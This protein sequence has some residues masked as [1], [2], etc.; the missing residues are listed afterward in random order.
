MSRPSPF[1]VASQNVLKSITAVYDFIWPTAAALWNLRWQVQGY[2]AARG[3]DV[4]VEELQA[5]FVEGSGIHGAN[6]R[7]AC[8]QQTWEQQRADFAII[9][10]VNLI[11]AYEVWT[12][13]LIHEVGVTRAKA[14]KKKKGEGPKEFSLGRYPLQGVDDIEAELKFLT[15]TPSS[16]MTREVCP[17]LSIGLVH[18]EKLGQM[19]VIYR[20]FKETRNCFMHRGRADEAAVKAYESVG[21]VRDMPFTLPNCTPL[22]RD[23]VV[24]ADLHGVVGFSDV[25]RRLVLTIDSALAASESAEGI[26]VNRWRAECG[27]VQA[28]ADGAKRLSKVRGGL[29]SFGLPR[30]PEV[31]GIAGALTAARLLL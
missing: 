15:G 13:E 21:R 24:V 30:L 1:F 12:D 9:A 29:V 18:R 7:R 11:A 5:R 3:S 8:L 10:L 31:A 4:T 28:P 2:T 19:L 16:A 25:L 17:Y 23:E 20:Y 26:L 27:V 6:L 14:K 22:I